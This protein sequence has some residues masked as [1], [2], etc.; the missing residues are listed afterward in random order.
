MHRCI[1]VNAAIFIPL[2][3]ILACFYKL[4]RVAKKDLLG[5]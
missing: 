5:A 1:D 2:T 4:T 3:T